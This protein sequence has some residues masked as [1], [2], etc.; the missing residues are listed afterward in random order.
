M[1]D[2]LRALRA[3]PTLLRV[4]LAG[5]I[6]Y[7]AELIVWMLTTTMPLVS[8][9][10]WSAVAE[11]A[12]IGRFDQRA[13]TGYFLASLLVRQLTGSWI[14]WELNQDIKNGTLAQKLLRPIHPL[15]L[16]A[17]D[18]LGVVPLRLVV[19]LPITA[20]ALHYVGPSLPRSPA[21]LVIFLASLFGAWAVNF[22]S[23][24]L[25][26]SLAFF[27]ESSSSIFDLWSVGFMLLSGYLVPLDLFPPSLRGV[28]LSLPFRFALAFPVDIATGHA[29]L[30][31]ALADLGTQA[32]WVV[33]LAACALA[34][35]R[36]GLKRYAAFGG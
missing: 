32:L 34:L 10:L 15:W 30:Q 24:T 4:G 13:F 11:N 5:G 6:A 7:R 29:T 8:L 25:I 12:P 28:A 22:F 17:A 9:A 21:L 33:A 3:F 18:N 20:L 2:A 23:M 35:F 16:Y 26:G 1:S 36:A 27:L 31:T 19:T 14:V